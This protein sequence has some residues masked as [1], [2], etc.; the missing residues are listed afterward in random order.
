MESNVIE[1]KSLLSWPKYRDTLLCRE[2]FANAYASKQHWNW[3][4]AQV[5][6]RQA[7]NRIKFQ[8]NK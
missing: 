2:G 8:N 4:E 3:I 5:V 6:R 7:R 1:I